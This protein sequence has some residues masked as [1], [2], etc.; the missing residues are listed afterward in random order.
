MPQTLQDLFTGALK[1]GFAEKK[2]LVALPKMAKAAQNAK[3][4]AAFDKHIA[5]TEAQVERLEKVF[6]ELGQAAKGKN[7][8]AVVAIIDEGKEIMDE[9]KGSRQPNRSSTMRSAGTAH[10]CVGAASGLRQT[11]KLLKQTP[12]EEEKTDKA[13]A[14]RRER[15]ES[16][17]RSRSRSGRIAVGQTLP[18]MAQRSTVSIR[19]FFCGSVRAGCLADGLCLGAAKRLAAGEAEVIVR[20]MRPRSGS[21][22]P[23]PA[24]LS[25]RTATVRAKH[26]PGPNVANGTRGDPRQARKPERAAQASARQTERLP[27]SKTF[28]LI[29]QAARNRRARVVAARSRSETSGRVRSPSPL[30]PLRCV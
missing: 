22:S 9:Y 15:C 19:D 11:T 18:G 7:C 25:V 28:V 13:F 4:T 21:A 6:R 2:I 17:S 3:L 5:E 20:T 26:R 1:D 24:I 29:R 30:Q 10:S 16:A 23:R 12:N 27:D 8:P 14:A